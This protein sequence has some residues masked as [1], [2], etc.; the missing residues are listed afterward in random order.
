MPEGR[1]VAVVEELRPDARERGGEFVDEQGRVI[2]RHPGVHH[3]TIG[4]RHGLGLATGRK[5]YV[6]HIDASTR[7]VT[8]GGAAELYVGNADV[9]SVSWISGEV[10]AAPV[11]ARVQIRHRHP[12]VP[13]TVVP[14]DGARASVTF[15][16]P[17]RAVTPGQAAVFYALE[18][19]DVVLGGGWIARRAP[20]HTA[21]ASAGV[22]Q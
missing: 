20:A 9:D 22:A 16:E 19:P 5:L 10:P 17:V 7:R 8:V 2:G 21:T 6:T 4:Q 12:G 3:F 1:Y 18:E 15:D 13:A 11:R 14:G